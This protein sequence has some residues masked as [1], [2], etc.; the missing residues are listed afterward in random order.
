MSNFDTVGY[1]HRHFGLPIAGP[2]NPP[3][4]LDDQ[5]ANFRLKFIH[6]EVFELQKALAENDLVEVADALVDIVVVAMGTAQLMGLP[7]EPLF[8]EIMKTNMMKT[9]ATKPEESKRHTILDLVKPKGWVRP[10]L[11]RILID[12]G[13]DPAKED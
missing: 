6:E 2:E 5:T 11:H 7:W 9:R 4:L 3:H 10:N 13:W 8:E 1:M 12:N